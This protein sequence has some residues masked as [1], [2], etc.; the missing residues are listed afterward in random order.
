MKRIEWLDFAKGV[1]ILFVV[2]VHVIEGMYKTGSFTQYNGFT[3]LAMGLLFTFVMPVFFALSG[4]LYKPVSSG[5]QY[6]QRIMNKGINLLVPYVI[7]AVIYVT[8]QH[9]GGGNVHDMI[10]WT[11]LLLMFWDPIGYL[12]FLEILFLIFVLVGALDLLRLNWKIQ[13]LVYTI[14]FGI[15][16]FVAIPWVP[17][18]VLM[19][20]LSFYLG[21]VFKQVPSLL[22]SRILFGLS[23]ILLIVSFVWQMHLGGQ[24]F[25]TNMFSKLNFVSKLASLFGVIYL[26]QHAKTSRGYQYFIKAGQWSLVIYLVH[27]PVTSILRTLLMKVGLTNYFAL[28]I[29]ILVATWL[30]SMLAAHLSERWQI[31]RM[32]FYPTRWWAERKFKTL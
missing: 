22:D 10:S 27:S 3:H 28:L 18:L 17:R 12:W 7:F 31:L 25:E 19:W 11:N 4:Y 29:I 24:W 13:L 23:V 26:Y 21:Y 14:L 32:I 8:L 30:I 5:N 2:I 9:F 15:S 20:T 1:T 16:L 6:R